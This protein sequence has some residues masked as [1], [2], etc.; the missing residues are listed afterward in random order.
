MQQDRVCRASRRL[1]QGKLYLI[2]I[3]LERGMPSSSNVPPICTLTGGYFLTANEVRL[4]R[5]S[6]GS[7]AEQ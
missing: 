7:G 5:L 6:Q 3:A 2:A 4:P 1:A